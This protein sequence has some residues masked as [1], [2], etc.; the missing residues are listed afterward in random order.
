MVHPILS[1][2]LRYFSFANSHLVVL[3]PLSIQRLQAKWPGRHVQCGLI[4]EWA[5][6][7][8]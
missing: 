7:G 5:A 6:L 1:V 4:H 3:K 2:F 8:S